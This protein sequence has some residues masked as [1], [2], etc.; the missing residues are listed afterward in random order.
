MEIQPG[1]HV[2]ITGASG[3]GKTTLLKVLCGLFPASEG[4]YL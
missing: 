2:A 4:I 3:T 1:E